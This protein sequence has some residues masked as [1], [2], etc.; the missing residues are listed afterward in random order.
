[1]RSKG[2]KNNTF[3]SFIAVVCFLTAGVCF[4]SRLPF[5]PVKSQD[6]LSLLAAGFI[7]PDGEIEDNSSKGESSK[8]SPYFESPKS[9][10]SGVTS[11]VEVEKREDF[12]FKSHEGE[13]TYKIIETQFG[14]AG[15]KYDNFYVKNTTGLDINIEEEL[16]KEPD[17]HISKNSGPQVLI[18]HTHTTESYMEFDQGFFYESF[19][20]R[21]SDNNRNVTRVGDAIATQ[22]KNAGIGVI[23]DTTHHDEPSYNGSYSR[24]A[25]T[26]L[27]NIS[28][29][30][31]IQVVLDIHRDAI[32]DKEN[33]KV[34]PTFVCNGKKA[35]QIMV[36]SGRD[37]DGSLGFP[38][39]EYN[40][41]LALRIQKA[42]E[43]MYPGLTRPMHF[44]EVKYNM[45]LTHGSILIEVGT[46]GNTLD[47]AVYSGS[48]LGNVLSEVLGNLS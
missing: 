42:A 41:R 16:Q 13:N 15:T 6:E 12:D 31:S 1:M 22:L 32:G 48:L 34:K 40:L 30:P 10:S 20:P 46:D 29:N 27:K 24:S 45:N 33:G 28:E 36:I 26:V 47:E 3:V 2:S 11:K 44:D 35:A 9:A 5:A 37:V 14:A 8:P 39:W 18:V 25:E 21:S 23:H 7:L 38:D 43:T 19:Y 17:V 4:I